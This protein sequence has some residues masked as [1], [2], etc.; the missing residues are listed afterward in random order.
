MHSNSLGEEDSD[1][2]TTGVVRW[3]ASVEQ[4]QI[5][6][7]YVVGESPK[8]DYSSGEFFH[9]LNPY[10]SPSKDTI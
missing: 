5:C 7:G 8:K 9:N 1:E 3:Y 6:E 10:L 2:E 4:E